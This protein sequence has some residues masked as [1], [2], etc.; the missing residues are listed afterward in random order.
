[1]D[2]VASGTL[3]KADVLLVGHHGSNSST[4]DPFLER[5]SPRYAVIQSGKNNYGHPTPEIIAKLANQNI[6][7]LRNDREGNIVFVS[8]GK[9]LEVK[10][11]PWEFVAGKAK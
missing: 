2:L 11:D 10:L 7:V 1:A 9:T 5:V 4:S 6:T 3:L 8:S